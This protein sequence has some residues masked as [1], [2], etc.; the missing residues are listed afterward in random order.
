MSRLV[1]GTE[2]VLR[3]MLKDEI[4]R[5][6]AMFLFSTQPQYY[7]TIPHQLPLLLTT[8]QNNAVDLPD[9]HLACIAQF[10]VAMVAIRQMK[11][12]HLELDLPY[13]P[14]ACLLGALRSG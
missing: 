5:L 9:G 2:V 6:P 7:L 3:E 14:E 1:F 11:D 8:D 13:C 10:Q 4:V 12:P